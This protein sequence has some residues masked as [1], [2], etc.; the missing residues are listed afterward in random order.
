[1]IPIISTDEIILTDGTELS[2]RTMIVDSFAKVTC[3]AKVLLKANFAVDMIEAIVCAT[4]SVAKYVLGATR[5]GAT[6]CPCCAMFA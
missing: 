2:G 3:F 6:K 4:R 5:N 1:M